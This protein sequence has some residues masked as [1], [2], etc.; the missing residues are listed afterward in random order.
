MLIQICVSKNY[1]KVHRKLLP[2]SAITTLALWQSE[3]RTAVNTFFLCHSL[4]L[5]AITFNLFSQEPSISFSLAFQLYLS[6]LIVLHLKVIQYKI[7]H[8]CL[9]GNIDFCKKRYGQ[10][11]NCTQNINDSCQMLLEKEMTQNKSNSIVANGVRPL[12]KLSSFLLPTDIQYVDTNVA[13]SSFV[14]R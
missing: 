11:N 4:T 6:L 10:I 12:A 7:F 5:Y 13:K 3:I 14:K 8:C 1:R 9:E 2:A